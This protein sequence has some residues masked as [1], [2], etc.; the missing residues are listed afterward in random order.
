MTRAFHMIIL[1]LGEFPWL[2]P[3]KIS[4]PTIFRY[5]EIEKIIYI[6]IELYK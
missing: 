1:I 5:Y 6:Y 2:S 3:S 4:F